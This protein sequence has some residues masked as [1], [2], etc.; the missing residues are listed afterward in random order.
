[1]FGLDDDQVEALK[2]EVELVL[3]LFETREDLVDRIVVNLKVDEERAVAIK[4]YLDENLFIT[5]EA[6]LDFADDQ[7][8]ENEVESIKSRATE[9][10]TVIPP[11]EEA[12]IEEKPLPNPEPQPLVKPLR[13][14]ADDINLNR[15]HGYGAF[16][17]GESTAKKEDEEIHRSSQDDIIKQWD[18]KYRNLLK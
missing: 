15:A 6:I 18:S 5:V 1:M 3:C 10:P 12:E 11:I 13:T 17:S 8:L 7:W 9:A 14:F 16:R 4:Q 2:I